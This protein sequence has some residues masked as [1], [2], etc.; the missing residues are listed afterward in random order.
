VSIGG[1]G[2]K[3]VS[4]KNTNMVNG[5]YGVFITSG[6][7]AVL[8]VMLQNVTIQSMGLSAVYAS[9]GT[10]EIMNSVLVQNGTAVTT[11]QVTASDTTIS[12]ES[13][14]I[15]QNGTAV[16]A[17][18]GGKIR[19]ENNDIFDNGTGVAAGTCTG[20]VKTNGN[21]RDSGNT[22]GNPLPAA[23]VSATALY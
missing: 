2:T 16:C 6:G 1:S 20:L 12:V 3:N 15:S 7:E 23:N 13:S 11:G 14:M 22:N 10:T 4:I 19:L 21:N 5:T 18:S 9:A 8:Q 17:T